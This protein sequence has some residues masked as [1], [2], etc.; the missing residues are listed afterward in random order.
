MMCLKGIMKHPSLYN[1]YKN[2]PGLSRIYDR[3]LFWMQPQVPKGIFIRIT[4]KKTN[5]Y[6]EL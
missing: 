5:F 6:G 2:I 4:V 1:E 3:Q